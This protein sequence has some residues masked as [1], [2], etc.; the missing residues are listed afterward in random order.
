MKLHCCSDRGPS[1]ILVQLAHVIY[2]I[3]VF[4][5]CLLA[6]PIHLSKQLLCQ[7]FGEHRPKPISNIQA[8]V[9]H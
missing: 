7:L 2:A 1:K 6:K 9:P 5:H 8:K 3:R 4:F